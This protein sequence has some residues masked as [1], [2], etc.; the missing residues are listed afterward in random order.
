[1]TTFLLYLILWIWDNRSFDAISLS[2]RAKNEAEIAYRAGNYTKAVELYHQLTYTSLFTEPAGRLYLAHAYFQLDSLEK[3]RQNYKLLINISD[4]SI[5]SIAHSQLG[6]LSVMSRDTSGAIEHL[7]T[8]LQLHAGNSKARYNYELL[9]RRFSGKTSL[10]EPPPQSPTPPPPTPTNPTEAPDKTPELAEQREELLQRLR[11]LNMSED[12]ARSILEAMKSNE[13]HYIF[14]LKRN[15][16]H[17]QAEQS[18]TI[19]W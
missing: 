5:A 9:K 2:N 14:Q 19:E 10:P 13:T 6:L 18:K 16:F 4:K 1:M 7:A 11:R 15:Q 3:A 8:A 17:N 12:Q